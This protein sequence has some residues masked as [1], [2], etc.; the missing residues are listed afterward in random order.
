MPTVKGKECESPT[1]SNDGEKTYSGPHG[2]T[3]KL[4]ERCYY[5]VVTPDTPPASNTTIWPSDLRQIT[6]P[7]DRDTISGA[8]RVDFKTDETR[9]VGVSPNPSFKQ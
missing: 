2:N 3:L 6:Q 8:S 1:C 7:Q 5:R 9:T 4:C